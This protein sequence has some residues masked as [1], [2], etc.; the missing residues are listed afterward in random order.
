MNGVCKGVI[1]PLATVRNRQRAKK[2]FFMYKFKR[3]WN[4]ETA[5]EVFYIMCYI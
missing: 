5:L 2:K 1:L 3:K 4:L